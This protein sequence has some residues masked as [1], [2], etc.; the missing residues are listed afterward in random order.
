MAVAAK[1]L[2]ER[3]FPKKFLAERIYLPRRIYSFRQKFGGHCQ[4]DISADDL[5]DIFF[6]ADLIYFFSVV[7]YMDPIIEV[8]TV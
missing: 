6:S 3:I 2:A 8:C 7:G 4:L 1:Y 5:A